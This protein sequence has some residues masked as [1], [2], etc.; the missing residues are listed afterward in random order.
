VGTSSLRRV[1]SLREARP[2]LTYLPVRGNVDTRLRKV[3]DGEFDAIVLAGAGLIRLG[4][5]ARA[6]E[7]L[8]ASVSLPAIGQGALGIELRADDEAARAVLAPLHD[9][10]SGMAV[11]AERGVMVALDGDCKTPI[12][13]HATRSVDHASLELRV[14]VA[15]PDGS[16][17]RRRESAT[18][19]PA[20]QE[21]AEAFGREVGG[22]LR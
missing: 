5:E 6:T 7:W 13:A 10:N 8:A 14:M 21:E 15:D 4:L 18:P 17:V 9:A 1:V 19:W 22:A 12:A 16:R 20:T 3:D 2:D 11:A